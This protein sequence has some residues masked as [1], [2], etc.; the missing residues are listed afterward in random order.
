M[1]SFGP[2]QVRSVSREPQRTN[3]DGKRKQ[4][5]RE[6]KKDEPH[7]DELN[8]HDVID[9]H[10]PEASAADVHKAA[11]TTTPGGKP[12]SKPDKPRLDLSA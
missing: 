4:Q 2:S 12:G 5:H 8:P 11:G 7:T 10:K 3:P 9:L 6:Q 1:S